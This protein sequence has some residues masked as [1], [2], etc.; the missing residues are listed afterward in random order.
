MFEEIDFLIYIFFIAFELVLKEEIH[1][2]FYNCQKNILKLLIIHKNFKFNKKVIK[3]YI[4]SQIIT[5]Y[6]N[7]SEINFKK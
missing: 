6:L 2:F 4:F 7:I 1:L 5:F 3:N